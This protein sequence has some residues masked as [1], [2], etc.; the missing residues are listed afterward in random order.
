GKTKSQTWHRHSL[1][2]RRHGPGSFGGKSVSVD[3][4]AR[5]WA[6]L[7]VFGI[8]LVSSCSSKSRTATDGANSTD[9]IISSTPPFQTREPEHY[10]AVR[11][12][13]FTNSSGKS[14]VTKTVIA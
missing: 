8:A 1:C 3:L 5:P 13:T 7:L 12:I 11:T 10:T 9:Q 14:F 2:Q 4:I 6:L